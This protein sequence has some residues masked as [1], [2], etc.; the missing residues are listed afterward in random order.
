MRAMKR[1]LL[2]IAFAS[3]M[4]CGTYDPCED[5]ACGDACTTCDPEDADCVETGDFK[6]C[7]SEL[8]CTS[9]VPAICGSR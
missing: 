2:A 1:F 9:A 8:I 6:V 7:N 5:K 3:A 4:G